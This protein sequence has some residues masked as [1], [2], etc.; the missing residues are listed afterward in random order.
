MSFVLSLNTVHNNLGLDKV[1][2]AVE[3]FLFLIKKCETNQVGELLLNHLRD[4]AVGLY[5]HLMAGS[6][7]GDFVEEKL[8]NDINSEL[9]GGY[10]LNTQ[11]ELNCVMVDY[12]IICILKVYVGYM[13]W[14]DIPMNNR[15]YCNCIHNPKSFLPEWDVEEEKYN[16]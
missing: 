3:L 4:H 14:S 6:V 9:R 2:D 7:N 16:K 12:D 11:N 10:S 8:T 15:G 1:K 13:S 5:N